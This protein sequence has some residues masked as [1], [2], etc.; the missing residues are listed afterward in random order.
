MPALQVGR[1]RSSN[2]T[3]HCRLPLVALSGALLAWPLATSA[4]H[5][6]ADVEFILD[7]RNCCG[8]YPLDPTPPPQGWQTLPAGGFAYEGKSLSSVVRVLAGATTAS[9]RVEVSADVLASLGAGDGQGVPRA[10]ADV[11]AGWSDTV[12][13]TSSSLP[14][15]TPLTAKVYRLAWSGGLA[16]A[17]GNILGQGFE[18]TPANPFFHSVETVENFVSVG[19]VTGIGAALRSAAGVEGVL[20]GQTRSGQTNA[21][22][23][24]GF[25]LLT[26]GATMTDNQ[27]RPLPQVNSDVWDQQTNGVPSAPLKPSR[28]QDT[29]DG[30]RQFTFDRYIIGSDRVPYDFD[31]AVAIGYEFNVVSGPQFATVQLPDVGDGR[32][33]IALWDGASWQDL[34]ADVLAGERFDLRT[35]GGP[36]GVGRLRVTGIETSAAVDPTTLNFVTRFTFEGSGMLT[37]TQT[38]LVPEPG[39][40]VLLAGGLLAVG[41]AAKR[42]RSADQGAHTCP[43][44]V[45]LAEA[46]NQGRDGAIAI[47]ATFMRVTIQT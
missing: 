26:P 30:G 7:F 23:T 2:D 25:E 36:A 3:P 10:S 35:H 8:Y 5:G 31:P 28:E 32:Y 12:H 21:I 20:A 47:P 39:T 13:A 43:E 41:A 27:D 11:W 37:M 16:R 45:A 6:N 4:G 24:W 38:S 42:R 18:L 19:G 44:P 40:W 22:I 17:T 46:Q 34:G 33:R 29:E 14:L 1:C 9:G 15:G